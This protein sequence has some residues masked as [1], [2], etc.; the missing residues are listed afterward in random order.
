MLEFWGMFAL[1]GIVCFFCCFGTVIFLFTISGAWWHLAI[2]IG[3]LVIWGVA[4]WKL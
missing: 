1:L 3:L 4:I 2:T